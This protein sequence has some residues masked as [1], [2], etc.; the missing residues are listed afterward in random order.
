M[1]FSLA[2]A[3]VSCDNDKFPEPEVKDNVSFELDIQ[4]ILTAECASCHNPSEVKPDFRE[5]YAYESM[6][7]LIDEGDIIPGD[8]E[9]SELVEMLE[10]ES[11]DGNTMPPAGPM[12]PQKIALIKKWIEEGA[13]NN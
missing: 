3:V 5:G 1:I 2:L 10:G 6:E 7:G 4:P 13:L 8:P 9:G 12:S 11:P